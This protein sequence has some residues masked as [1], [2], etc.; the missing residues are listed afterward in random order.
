MFDN[1]NRTIKRAMMVAQELGKA[2]GPMPKDKAPH[3]ASMVPGVHV[4]DH[5]MGFASGGE[6]QPTDETGFDAYHGSPHEFPAEIGAPLGRFRLDK[7]GTGEGAQAYGHGLYLGEE[8]TARSYR[9]ALSKIGIDQIDSMRVAARH[10]A[11]PHEALDV[12]Y[13]A[14][15]NNPTLERAVFAAN[16]ARPDLAELPWETTMKM[17]EAAKKSN[18][19]GHLY[20]VRV[21]ANPEH[22]LDWNKRLSQQSPVV[23]KALESLHNE[24]M[25]YQSEALHPSHSGEQLYYRLAARFGKNREE[26][27]PATAAA[28]QSAGIP[29]IRYLDAMSRGPNGNPTYNHVIF[30]PNIIN[31]KRRYKRGGAVPNKRQH[32]TINHAISL[33]NAPQHAKILAKS[34][35]P[36][37]R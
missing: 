25:G 10:H 1:S 32:P 19:P 12:L 7:I 27:A 35:L 34:V 4:S 22:F 18:P 2:I 5:P 6:V 13:K 24:R 3:L 28:L 37:R 21:N 16:F 9:D 17:A 23:Q 11:I 30:D 31:I 15:L 8:G 26:N 29:G 36:G 14:V 33:T 20:H